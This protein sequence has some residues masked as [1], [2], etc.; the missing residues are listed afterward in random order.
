[1]QTRRAV[2]YMGVSCLLAANCAQ[3]GPEIQR[4]QT[5]KGT[6][7]YFVE[8]KGLPLVDIQFVFDAGSARDAEK[9]G[10]AALTSVL[11]DKGAGEWD[12]GQIAGRLE[13]VGAEL[14]TGASQDSAWLTLR[15]LTETR[16]LATALKTTAKVLTSP[17]FG[18]NDFAREQKRILAA[19]RRYTESPA[20]VVK[21]AFFERIYQTHPYAHQVLGETETV[22]AIT[23]R[24]IRDFY[25]KYYVASNAIAVVVG[26]V[27]REKAASMVEELTAELKT[28]TR[29]A[30]IPPVDYRAEGHRE[31]VSFPS[32]QT[33]IYAGMPALS[34]NDPD[35]FALYVGNH[36]LGGNGLVSLISEEIREKRGLA[37]SSSSIFSP[38]VR[39]G[40]FIMGLQTR[41]DQADEALRVL[42]ETIGEFIADGPKEEELA[43]AKKNLTGGFVLRIDS[44]SKVSDYVAMI[45]FYG[46]PLDYLDTFPSKVDAVTADEVKEAFQSHLRLEQFQ[47]ILV[48]GDAKSGGN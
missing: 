23:A 18:S 39:K 36:V 26:D 6:R 21:K 4:W 42:N 35:F 20:Q 10:L 19:L 8:A 24:E 34:Q 33:H 12:A 41:N 5:D 9:F 48:G 31:S 3:A 17:R 30:A 32:A 47:T 27:T 45:G 44:N 16:I 1:M 2:F 46:L 22:Q 29:P 25:L 38:M 28:G 43:N 11:L 15:S 7:V 14:G 37:Y 40:P 13:G